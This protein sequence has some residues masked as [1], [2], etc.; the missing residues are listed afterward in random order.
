MALKQ[1]RATNKG[2]EGFEAPPAG[3]HAGYLVAIVDLGTQTKTFKGES[4]EAYSVYL[5][6][7]LTDCPMSGTKGVN[8]VIGKEFTYS[9]HVKSGLRQLVEKWAGGKRSFAEGEEFDLR[10]LFGV[11]CLVNV[12]NT[13]PN[14]EGRVFAALEGVS[15]LPKGLAAK[16]SQH[17]ALFWQIEDG[18]PEQ[19]GW[20][21]WSYGNKVAD[22]VQGSPEWKQRARHANGKTH[23]E[24]SASPSRQ[25]DAEEEPNYSDPF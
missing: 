13:A 2:G 16:P 10:K 15:P 9:F 24:P 11:P 7:E 22:L 17:K 4:R 5:C 21:P 18:D 23:P 14:E 19:L 6:W 12:S 3:N 1:L 20:L 8:H 25:D